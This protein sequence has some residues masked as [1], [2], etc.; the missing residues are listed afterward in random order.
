MVSSA[1]RIGQSPSWPA[2]PEIGA[3]TANWRIVW[4]RLAGTGTPPRSDYNHTAGFPGSVLGVG[5]RRHESHEPS[6]NTA[7]GIEFRSSPPR[8]MTPKCRYRLPSDGLAQ[9]LPPHRALQSK[10]GVS[11][12]CGLLNV[13]G[14]P[15]SLASCRRL[16]SKITLRRISGV[17]PSKSS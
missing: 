5:S 14:L 2:L 1:G 11:I 10:S 16:S 6:G 15:A 17:I 3:G 13:A 8:M 12:F 4:A 7:Q 9:I